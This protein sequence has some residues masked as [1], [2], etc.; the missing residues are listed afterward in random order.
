MVRD[1]DGRLIVHAHLDGLG[2]AVA[3]LVQETRKEEG[4]L[5]RLGS[6]H[7]ISASQ[8]ESATL[9]CFLE[10]QEMTTMV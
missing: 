5:G 1:C 9:I 10:P 3:E 2:G 7:M 4:F 8:E 6:G